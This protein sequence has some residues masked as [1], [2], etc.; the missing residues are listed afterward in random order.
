MVAVS[1]FLSDAQC[2]D[3][4]RSVVFAAE[5]EDSVLLAAKYLDARYGTAFAAKLV[6]R[7]PWK[8]K[9]KALRAAAR[10]PC[11]PTSIQF[12]AGEACWALQ[13]CHAVRHMVAHSAAAYSSGPELEGLIMSHPDQ[14]YMLV[15]ELPALV[16]LARFA[17]EAAFEVRLLSASGDETRPSG[18]RPRPTL[19]PKIFER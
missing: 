8:D 11:V 15:S 16:D 9:A 14:Q 4:G 13:A 12:L 2:A 1:E 6:S 3:I 5:A 10:D 19:K 18:L 17:R 7:S